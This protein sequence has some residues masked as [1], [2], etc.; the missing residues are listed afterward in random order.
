MEAGYTPLDINVGD[1]IK[2]SVKWFEHII[3]VSNGVSGTIKTITQRPYILK[4]LDSNNV[5]DLKL[6]GKCTVYK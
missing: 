4:Y 5:E 2:D 6:L 3:H 1:N